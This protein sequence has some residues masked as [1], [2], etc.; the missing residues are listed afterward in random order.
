VLILAA[1]NVPWSVDPAFRRPGRFDRVLFVPPP[2]RPARA[3]I[4]AQLLAD[5]PA[6]SGIDVGAIAKRT[7]GFSG[8][9]LHDLVETAADEAIAQS[10]ASGQEQPIS[11]AHLRE[12][13]AGARATTLE[14]LTTARNYARYANEGGQYDEVVRFLEQNARDR[15]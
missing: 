10:I 15:T 2:D 6:M 7:G 14:W 12:A 3:A 13:L 9:D 8:A 1:T 11:E 4:L 5:R